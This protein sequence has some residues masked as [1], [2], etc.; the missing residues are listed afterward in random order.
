MES[1]WFHELSQGLGQYPNALLLAVAAT[2]FFE[3]LAVVGLVVPGIAMLFALAVAAG[4]I[5]LALLPLLAAACVG[6]IS[7]DLLSYLIGRHYQHRIRDWSLFQ[8]HPDW[9]AKG[10]HFFKQYG[11]ISI[12][13]GRFLGP[14]RP[15]M[16]M[17]AGMLSMQANRFIPVNVLSALAW[18][19][20]YLLPG[21]V[22][23]AALDGEG[24][25][26]HR[27]LGL[28]LALTLPAWLAAQAL[29][30]YHYRIIPRTQ[31]RAVAWLMV[32]ATGI[33]FFVVNLL[34]SHSD[35]LAHAN[36]WLAHELQALR[37]P[38]LDTFFIGLTSLGY[39]TPMVIWAA[40]ITGVLLLRHQYYLAGVWI[41]VTLLG[42]T[43]TAAFKESFAIPRPELVMQPPVSGAFPS[44]HTSMITVFVG[45]LVLMM[46]PRLAV[47]R[48][49]ALLSA[50]FVLITLVAGARLYL[51]V[52]WLS[53]ILGGLLLGWFLCL[54]SYLLFSYRPFPA[55]KPSDL[56]LASA[57][58]LLINLAFV[59]IPQWDE[60]CHRYTPRP[61]TLI[62]E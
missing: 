53:D 22:T 17:I 28:L 11:L 4:S 47:P 29:W 5:N 54:L 1:T 2:A 14:L 34:F 50:A 8:R 31:A 26:D 9:L 56:L 49:K 44:G 37:H 10:E 6:A 30:F 60:H 40:L 36:T 43:L 39:Q 13:L 41:G 57:L 20:F 19:P 38:W 48:Q 51:G 59:A 32:L 15:F 61:T 24:T 18:A 45:L 7:G 52:H 25:F 46:L 27:H 58:A 42:R 55:P 16:P 33:G 12:V 35:T 23:G 21:Y 62:T 3:S